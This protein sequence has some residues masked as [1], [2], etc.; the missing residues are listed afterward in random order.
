MVERRGG[1]RVLIAVAACSLPLGAASPASAQAESSELRRLK[2]TVDQM[3]RTI[4]QLK[5]KI[6]RME[7]DA[8]RKDGKPASV[9][10]PVTPPAPA[11]K[12]AA[13][14]GTGA[15]DEPFRREHASDAAARGMASPIQDR[16]AFRDEQEAAPRPGNLPLDPEYRGFVPIPNTP[17]LLRFNAKPRVDLTFDTR[18]PGDDNRF[19]TA[20]IP[21]RDDPLYGGGS[22]FN[23]NAKGSQL[24]VDAR[25]PDLP[26]SP[27]FYYQNDFFGSGG[28]EFPYRLR[29]LYG[30]W[31]NLTIGQAF[32]VFEDPDVWPDTVDYEGP[33]AMIFARRPLV[34]YAVPLDDGWTLNFGIEQPETLAAA[35]FGQTVTAQNHAPDGTAN[36]RWEVAKVGHA[37]FATVLRDLGVRSGTFGSGA[38]QREFGDAQTFGWGVNATAAFTVFDTDSAQAL[39]TYGHGLGSYGNDTGFFNNDVALDPDG[40]L[41]AIPYLGLFAGYTHRWDDDWRSTATYGYVN[42]EP[43]FSQGPTAYKRTHYASLNLIWQLRKRFSVGLETLYGRNE[44]ANG[45]AGDVVR[46]QLGFLYSI[47]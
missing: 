45:S 2:T 43:Q 35:Y 38:N 8:A 1:W 9:A 31:Y 41:T 26:G 12:V 44:Q 14:G 42:Q 16:D 6:E 21:V 18:N 29:F 25:A 30:S 10:A 27:R 33:N 13:P 3:G 5:A 22:V 47:F 32:S 7:R 36:V 4:E 20:K 37:Q 15:G 39:A 28:G 46:F 23:V 19:V 40:D 24:S 17:V 34:R 11:P